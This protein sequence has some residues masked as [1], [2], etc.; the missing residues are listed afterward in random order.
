MITDAYSTGQ[1][2]CRKKMLKPEELQYITPSEA[3]VSCPPAHHDWN[4]CL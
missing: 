2:I 3:H 1:E 4:N